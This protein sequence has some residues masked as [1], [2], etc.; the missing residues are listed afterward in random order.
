MRWANGANALHSSALTSM[1]Q[2]PLSI[3]A[4]RFYEFR[5]SFVSIQHRSDGGQGLRI[6]YCAMDP[7]THS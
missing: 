3:D 4:A 1:D 2:G 5:T 7:G 6:K